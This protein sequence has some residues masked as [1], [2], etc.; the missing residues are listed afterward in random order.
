ME[1]QKI[2]NLL[3]NI[4]NQPSKFRTKHWIKTNDQS[5]VTCNTNSDIKIKTTML[6]SSQLL[7]QEL[8]QMQGK[9][10]KEITV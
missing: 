7:E 10:M 2:V 9:E 8:I 5:R 6:K 1:Y 4:S 3:D